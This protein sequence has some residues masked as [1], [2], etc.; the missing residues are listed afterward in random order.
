ME[1]LEYHFNSIYIIESLRE[2]DT[3]TGRTLY[4]DWL[5]W[6]IKKRHEE[7]GGGIIEVQSLQG[8]S[9]AIK[10]IHEEVDKGAYPLIHLEVHGSE[11]GIQFSN[12]ETLSWEEV[13]EVFRTINKRIEHNLVVTLAVCNGGHFLRGTPP[14][15]P[16]PVWGFLGSFEE[17]TEGQIERGFHAFYEVLLNTGDVNAAVDRLKELGIDHIRFFNAEMIFERTWKYHREQH[18]NP[19][20]IKRRLSELWEE[21]IRLGIV[22]IQ[23]KRAWM[24]SNRI[25]MVSNKYYLQTKRKFLH[26]KK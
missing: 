26:R 9:E 1:D 13:G 16:A 12:N 8:F 23:R 25:E 22:D 3:K 20:A 21:A 17:L 18:L 15:E 19:E 10:R 24:R 11:E 5:K 7:L 2:G 4:N 6:E 14:T